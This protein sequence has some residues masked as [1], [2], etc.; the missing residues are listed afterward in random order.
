MTL[1]LAPPAPAAAAGTKHPSALENAILCRFNALLKAENAQDL[2]A[3][4]ALFR[5]SEDT[6]FV[7][8]TP[9]GA[10]E[11]WGGFWGEAATTQISALWHAGGFA[12]AERASPRVTRLGHGVVQLYAPVSIRVAYA[13]QSGK[14]RPFL[15]ILDWVRERGIWKIASDIAIPAG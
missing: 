3:T 2:P 13:G 5:V 6:L 9:P 14:P 12:V 1:S 15:L 11:S 10:A 8:K 7:G 4:R